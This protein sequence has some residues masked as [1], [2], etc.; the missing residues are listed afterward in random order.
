MDASP[1]FL[2]D[3]RHSRISL[4]LLNRLNSSVK[5]SF[6]PGTPYTVKGPEALVVILARAYILFLNHN[7]IH[8]LTKKDIRVR[9]ESCL[10]RGC[11]IVVVT[12][13]RGT[14]LELDKRTSHRATTAVS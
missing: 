5:L 7:E 4:E 2:A 9:A 14:E 6:A 1:F 13:G 3:D 8:Q 10:Y 12:L 11:Y